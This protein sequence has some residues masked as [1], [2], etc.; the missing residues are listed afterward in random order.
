MNTY[1]Y[2]DVNWRVFGEINR[3][4]VAIAYLKAKEAHWAP[5][6]DFLW[7]AMSVMSYTRKSERITYTVS[8]TDTGY[9]FRMEWG[10]TG[11]KAQV[12]EE[13]TALLKGPE[14]PVT[15]KTE[16]RSAVAH[17]LEALLA[18][19][20][21]FS[22][23]ITPGSTDADATVL[24]EAQVLFSSLVSA[25]HVPRLYTDGPQ[26]Q[27]SIFDLF[28]YQDLQRRHLRMEFLVGVDHEL[29]VRVIMPGTNAELSLG[30]SSRAHK[31]LVRFLQ[32]IRNI[33][34]STEEKVP[35][36]NVATMRTTRYYDDDQEYQYTDED[37]D[38]DDLPWSCTAEV[39][40]TRYVHFREDGSHCSM[41][42]RNLHG[43]RRRFSVLIREG[44]DLALEDDWFYRSG[45]DH[46][47]S[48]SHYPHPTRALM[49]APVRMAFTAD[50]YDLRVAVTGALMDL[51]QQLGSEQ[52]AAIYG[53]EPPLELLQQI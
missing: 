50:D 16:W 52:Y 48:S 4:T 13:Y 14:K 5:L 53:A 19:S 15:G 7:H 20:S 12:I 28:D 3:G 43:W 37:P 39:L 24:L 11:V 42:L 33:I 22:I 6:T 27:V 31:N 9:S 10:T 18:Y 29:A 1:T 49:E 47:Q 34:H 51:V 46:L 32:A 17:S 26:R 41:D 8:E 2:N 25:P 30:D 44:A 45:G 36:V 38:E 35:C 23:A 21:T 40:H